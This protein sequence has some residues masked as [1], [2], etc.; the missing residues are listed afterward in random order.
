M[1]SR[2]WFD[3]VGNDIVVFSKFKKMQYLFFESYL[4]ICTENLNCGNY[5]ENFSMT[6]SYPKEYV[7]FYL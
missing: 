7:K 6:R 5:H 2:F 1:D 4:R 3:R